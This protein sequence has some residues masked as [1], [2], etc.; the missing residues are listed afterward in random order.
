M[1]TTVLEGNHEDKKPRVTKRMRRERLKSELLG[2]AEELLR[3]EEPEVHIL[4]LNKVRYAAMEA[5]MEL[6]SLDRRAGDFEKQCHSIC[7]A[8]SQALEEAEGILAWNHDDFDRG[9]WAAE[10]QESQVS[11]SKE[12]IHKLL[13]KT[14]AFASPSADSMAPAQTSQDTA[15]PNAADA[16]EKPI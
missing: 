16:S 2:Q 7:V 3:L 11:D 8:L 5:M 12:A 1:A 13:T 6:I 14:A 4:P 15:S 10:E 9:L